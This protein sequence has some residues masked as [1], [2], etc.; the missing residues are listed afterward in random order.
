MLEC[1]EQFLHTL[2][3]STAHEFVPVLPL[4]RDHPKDVTHKV[5]VIK[6]LYNFGELG[7]TLGVE[8]TGQ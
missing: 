6:S 3:C 2:G 8:H 1:L 5:R 4:P 7:G